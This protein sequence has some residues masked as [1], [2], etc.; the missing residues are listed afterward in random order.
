MLHTEQKITK[1]SDLL[2]AEP[3]ADERESFKK[4]IAWQKSHLQELT[5]QLTV[6]QEKLQ[7]MT[8]VFRSRPK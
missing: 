7:R 4:K 2:E 1:M 6:Q 3:D 8:Y 5:E